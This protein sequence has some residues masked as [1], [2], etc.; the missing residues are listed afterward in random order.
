VKQKPFS[1]DLR[2]NVFCSDNRRADGITNN[3]ADPFRAFI[4]EKGNMIEPWLQ[5]L[6][7]PMMNLRFPSSGD[8][9]M[10]YSPW[11]NWGQVSARAGSPRIESEIFRDVAL[12][13]KQLGRLIEAVDALVKVVKDEHPDS[14]ARHEEAFTELATMTTDILRK[15]DD[16]KKVARTQAEDALKLLRAADY[17]TFRELIV[18]YM[19]DAEQTNKPGD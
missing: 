15:K 18:K 14:C 3:G 13:G 11:T 8:V 12:P 5:L 1:K 6:Y 17:E 10:D 2:W 7:S 9:T 16:L 4:S 19:Q